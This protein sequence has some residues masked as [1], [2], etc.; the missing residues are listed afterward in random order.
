MRSF[1]TF[2]TACDIMYAIAMRRAKVQDDEMLA[3]KQF[4]QIAL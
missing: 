4:R 3:C 2:F 1:Y